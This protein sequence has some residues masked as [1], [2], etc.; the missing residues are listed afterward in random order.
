MTRVK[1]GVISKKHHKYILSLSKGFIGRRKNN[2][3]IAKQAVIKSLLYS[4]FD[5]KLKKR[6]FRS[7][8]IS[9][10]SSFLKIYNFKYN[11]FINCLNIFSFKLNRKSLF[12]LSLDFYNFI[13]FFSILFFYYHYI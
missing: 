4:Y 7:F 2:F 6:N 11:F 5:R 12:Y 13:K 3:K 9:Y 8:W 10:L 1:R